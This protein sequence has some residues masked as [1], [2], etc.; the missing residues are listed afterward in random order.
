VDRILHIL[1]DKNSPE[2]MMVIAKEANHHPDTLSVLLIQEAVRMSP[3]LPVKI[4]VLEEDVQ[5]RGGVREENE[6]I[7]YSKMLD[8]ILSFDSVVIW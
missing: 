7:N 1:K 4:Y 8:L 5:T 2:A 6:A 3:N